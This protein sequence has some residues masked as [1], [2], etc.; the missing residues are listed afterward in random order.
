MAGISWINQT[1][2]LSQDIQKAH[3]LF[4]PSSSS[5]TLTDNVI[6]LLQILKPG[7]WPKCHYVDRLSLF[8]HHRSGPLFGRYSSALQMLQQ[9]HYTVTALWK[10]ATNIEH[11][12]QIF[13]AKNRRT[14]D[15]YSVGKNRYRIDVVC[16]MFQFV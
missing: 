10:V 1:F 6:G 7:D 14:N 3:K 9:Q 15:K 4:I 16:H 2:A 5:L 8:L 11:S 13:H 12:N